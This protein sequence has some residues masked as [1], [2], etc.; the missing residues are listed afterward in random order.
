MSDVR[1][2]VRD[3]NA[4]NLRHLLLRSLQTARYHGYRFADGIC[5]RSPSAADRPSIMVSVAV[6][7]LVMTAPAIGAMR[8]RQCPSGVTGARTD[9]LFYEPLLQRIARQ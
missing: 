9:A 8:T 5:R 1:L 3:A 2:Y 7:W 4:V 6:A